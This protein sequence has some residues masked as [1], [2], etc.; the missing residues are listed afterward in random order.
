MREWL[1][2]SGAAEEDLDSLEEKA[3]S[4]H[5]SEGKIRDKYPLPLLQALLPVSIASQLKTCIGESFISTISAKEWTR[6]FPSCPLWHQ[7]IKTKGGGMI[8]L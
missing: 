3:R 5:L 2:V 4:F 1:T 6:N 7:F 8:E